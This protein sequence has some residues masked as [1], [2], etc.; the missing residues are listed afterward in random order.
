M[1]QSIANPTRRRARTGFSLVE[2]LVVIAIIVLLISIVVPA[3]SA[4]R[5]AAKEASTNVMLGVLSTGL[6]T[7]EADRR[8][9]GRFPPSLPDLRPDGTRKV[10]DPYHPN[11][12]RSTTIEISGAGLLVWALAGADLLG[13]PGFRTFDTQNSTVWNE[14]S[15]RKLES[16]PRKSGAFALNSNLQPV[17]ARSGPYVDLSK[18]NVTRWDKNE[19]S[20]VIPAELEARSESGRSAVTREYPMFLDSFGYPVLYWRADPAGVQFA[21]S[22]SPDRLPSARRGIYHWIDNEALVNSGARDVLVLRADNEVHKLDYEPGQDPPIDP[23]PGFFQYY[24]WNQDV[25]A[26]VHPQRPDSYLLVSPG[27]DGLYGTAD[28]IANFDHGGR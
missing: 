4:A 14:D 8:I 19:G 2:L 22:V 10:A 13:T 28:D 26:K 25:G 15:H 9:G 5:R 11:S 16:D 17:H 20:F 24:I 6:Q 27:A 7:F 3:L 23:A 1:S 18:I 21:D 12:S